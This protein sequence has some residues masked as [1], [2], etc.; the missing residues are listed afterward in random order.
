MLLAQAIQTECLKIEE[1]LDSENNSSVQ[2]ESPDVWF[3][4][5]NPQKTFHN[6]VQTAFPGPLE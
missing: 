3:P 4:W 1:G 5:S 2:E 6:D